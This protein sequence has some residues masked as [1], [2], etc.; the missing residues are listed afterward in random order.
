MTMLLDLDS[1][2]LR[3]RSALGVCVAEESVSVPLTTTFTG[4]SSAI[5]EDRNS[6]NEKKWRRKNDG[7]RIRRD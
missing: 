6:D 2:S 4:E 7:K 3:L 1:V 5:T